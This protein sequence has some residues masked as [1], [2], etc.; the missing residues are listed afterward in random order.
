[1]RDGETSCA[2]DPP[3]PGGEQPTTFE[4]ISGNRRFD[5][6]Y[7]L[8]LELQ[9]KLIRR[10]RVLDIGT[11]RSLDLSSSGILFDAGRC[12]PVG[13]NVEL[14]I[15]WPV[16]LD[17]VAPLKLVVSGRIVRSDGGRAAIRIVQHEFRAV[18]IHARDTSRL[19]S[20][21]HST[22]HEA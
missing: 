22:G 4:G 14:A 9:W 1:L 2:I 12:L 18:G 8:Q 5:R 16:L 17:K 6:R 13:F 3:R 19:V 7:D 20:Q 21:P 10:R 11:G 15:S